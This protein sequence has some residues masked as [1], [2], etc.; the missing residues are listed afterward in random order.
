M[1]L[2]TTNWMQYASYYL[3]ASLVIILLFFLYRYMISKWNRSKIS[4]EDFV[5]FYSLENKVSS[6]TVTF[7]FETYSVKHIHFYITDTSG[8]I[9]HTLIDQEMTPG[10]HSIPFDTKKLINDTYYYC[11]KTSNQLTEKVMTVEND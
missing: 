1:I 4:K 6:N 7:F 9:L 2:I 5:D 11:L 10:G 3:Y 8:N